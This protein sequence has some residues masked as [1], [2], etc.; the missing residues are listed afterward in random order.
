ML[1][2]MWLDNANTILVVVGRQPVFAFD[3]ALHQSSYHD[4]RIDFS[5]TL[6]E[7]TDYSTV[8]TQAYK[9]GVVSL[10]LGDMPAA[11]SSIDYITPE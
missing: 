9:E 2:G 3:E 1:G 7:R 4:H 5:H 10:E 11:S 8:L 6:Y